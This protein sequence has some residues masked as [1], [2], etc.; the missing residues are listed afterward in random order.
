MPVGTTIAGLWSE[1]N[2]PETGKPLNTCTMIITQPNKF[3]ADIHDRM[4]VILEEK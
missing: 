4:P 2:N 3:V 1:W